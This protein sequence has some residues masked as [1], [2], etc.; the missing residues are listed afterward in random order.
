MYITFIYYYKFLYFTFCFICQF[1][2][3]F[4]IAVVSSMF[5][6]W[7]MML[8]RIV[9]IHVHARHFVPVTSISFSLILQTMYERQN[10]RIKHF[11]MF[12]FFCPVF[13]GPL[14]FIVQER[15]FRLLIISKVNLILNAFKHFFCNHFYYFCSLCETMKIYTCVIIACSLFVISLCKIR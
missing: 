2:V 14:L 4:R 10:A 7:R 6:S 11:V 3:N 15:C 8:L 5:N 12:D 13:V 1:E 9:S